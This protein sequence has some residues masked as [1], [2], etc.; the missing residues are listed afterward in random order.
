M[1]GLPKHCVALAFTKNTPTSLVLGATS[2]T[3]PAPRV[4]AIT[5]RQRRKRGVEEGWSGEGRRGGVEG[6]RETVGGQ[7][8]QRAASAAQTSVLSIHWLSRR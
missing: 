7:G 3:V 1:K 6:K 8:S 4:E 2:R 5:G